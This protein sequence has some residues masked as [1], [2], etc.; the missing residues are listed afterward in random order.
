MHAASDGAAPA[1]YS[2]GTTSPPGDGNPQG[3]GTQQVLSTGADQ[4]AS[5]TDQQGT[6]QSPAAGAGAVPQEQQAGQVAP[7][8]PSVLLSPAECQHLVDQACE[9]A[10]AQGRQ[11][12]LAELLVE[13]SWK[14]SE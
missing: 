13:P 12:R 11:P 9:L 8:T 1:T 2:T 3:P 10:A 7:S 5:L 6:G 4:Q 14:V